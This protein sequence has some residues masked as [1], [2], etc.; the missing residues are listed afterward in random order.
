[1]VFDYRMTPTAEHAH[2]V[3]PPP[4]SLEVVPDGDEPST[5][6]NLG[7]HP[8][9]LWPEDIELLHEMWLKL[10]AGEPGPQLHHR[11]VVGYAL[12][13]LKDEYEGGQKVEIVKGIHSAATE[14]THA[15]E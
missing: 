1:M 5:F 11:D 14:E 2:Y 15:P 13:R 8:P 10:S 3:I 7:P 12:R 4:L 9:R 6:L